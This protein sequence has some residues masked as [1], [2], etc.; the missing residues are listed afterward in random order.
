MQ[1]MPE[2]MIPRVFSFTVYSYSGLSIEQTLRFSCKEK[3]TS[4]VN[5]VE[6]THLYG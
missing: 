4:P 3:Q 6:V 2:Q 5:Y 1:W